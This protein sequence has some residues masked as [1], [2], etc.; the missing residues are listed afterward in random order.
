MLHKKSCS[1]M[2][3]NLNLKS[4]SEGFKSSRLHFMEMSQVA[5]VG[6]FLNGLLRLGWLG[7]LGLFD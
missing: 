4:A 1:A 7:F 3:K 5:Y 6:L 2:A